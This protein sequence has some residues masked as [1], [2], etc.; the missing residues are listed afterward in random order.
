MALA[1][2]WSVEGHLIFPGFYGGIVISKQLSSETGAASILR[3][4]IDEQEFLLPIHTNT[5]DFDPEISTLA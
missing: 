5:I 4:R 2:C 1:I 3:G